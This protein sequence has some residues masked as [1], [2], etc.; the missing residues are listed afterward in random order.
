VAVDPQYMV[1]NSAWN[2]LKH[3]AVAARL[4]PLVDENI[5][6][7]CGPLEI[8]ALYSAKNPEDYEKLRVVRLAIFTYLEADDTDWQTALATQRGLAAKSQ[9]RGP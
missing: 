1:D 4:K 7:T 6:A 2:R 3:E 8:E 5:V 9:H